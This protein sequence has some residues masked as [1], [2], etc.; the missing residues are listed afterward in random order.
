MERN[1]EAGILSSSPQIVADA[2]EYFNSTYKKQIKK[3]VEEKRKEIEKSK[4]EKEKIEKEIEEL[5]TKLTGEFQPAEP[6][7]PEGQTIE[8]QAKAKEEAI[9]QG[10]DALKIEISKLIEEIESL[11]LLRGVFKKR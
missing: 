5:K 10:Q 3:E 7:K 8:E 4:V 6:A 11:K 2:R 9:Q 1:E